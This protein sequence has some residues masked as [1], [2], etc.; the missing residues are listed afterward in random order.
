[1]MQPSFL[2]S[3]ASNVRV[4]PQLDSESVPGSTWK[5]AR[6]KDKNPATCSQEMNK[7]KPRQGCCEKLQRGSVC[8]I[9][10]SCGQLQRGVENET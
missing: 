3:D 8:D 1:M 7:D 6:N 4:N 5:L 2:G 9:S 10:G